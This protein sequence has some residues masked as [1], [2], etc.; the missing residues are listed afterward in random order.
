MQYNANFV[1]IPEKKKIKQIILEEEEAMKKNSVIILAIFAVI[2]IFLGISNEANAWGKKKTFDVKIENIER[3][4]YH[5][6]ASFTYW[7]RVE[8]HKIIPI[9]FRHSWWGYEKTKIIIY[10][11]LKPDE[12]MWAI[13]RGSG[14]P[15]EEGSVVDYV[16]IH[17]HSIKEIQGGGWNH[18]KFGR[19]TTTVVE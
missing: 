12:K 6:G 18:G 19:G 17:V 16:E 15:H 10:D 4:H 2:V 11:D 14:D 3:I 5:E 8:G 7:Q 13:E 1:K 9:R